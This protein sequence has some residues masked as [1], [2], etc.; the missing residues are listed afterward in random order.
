VCY[1]SLSSSI[2]IYRP[3]LDCV[4][5]IYRNNDHRGNQ[6]KN[7]PL[8]PNQANQPTHD[9]EGDHLIRD[10]QPTPNREGNF[11]NI[12]GNMLPPQS[13]RRWRRR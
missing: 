13:K 8:A 3:L 11:L 12:E 10:N 5:L 4:H 1:I 6:R 9:R 7:H 2:I